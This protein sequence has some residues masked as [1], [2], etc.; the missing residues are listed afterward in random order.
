M[1]AAHGTIYDIDL[2]A[3]KVTR[4]E[5]DPDDIHRFAGGSGLEKP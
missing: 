5:L 1:F 3:R 4:R 2:T